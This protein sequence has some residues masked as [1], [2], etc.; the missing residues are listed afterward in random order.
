MK[1]LSQLAINIFGFIGGV[2]VMHT[3]GDVT[4]SQLT[5][6]AFSVTFVGAVIWATSLFLIL[7]S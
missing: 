7:D 1:R 2:Y 3:F 4:L 5:M 6:M